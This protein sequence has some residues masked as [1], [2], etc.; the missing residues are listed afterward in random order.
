MKHFKNILCVIER[1][2]DEHYAL[3]RAVALAEH[4]QARVMV[5]TVTEPVR[6]V[7]R[8]SP[9]GI[10]RARLQDSLTAA[11][12]EYLATLI[13]PYKARVNIT[14]KVLSGPPFLEVVREVLREAHDLVIKCPKSPDWLDRFLSSDDMHLLRKC[15]CPVWLVK[16]QARES[17]H[18]ILAGVDVDDGYAPE[19]LETRRALNGMVVELAG[20]LAV[21]ELAQL[22]VANAWEAPGE[23]VMRY[24]AFMQRPG[25]EVDDYVEQV[26][27]HHSQLLDALM[28]QASA[29]LGK[30]AIDHIKPQLHMPKGTARK[31]IP[32]LAKQ[33]RVDCIVMGTVARTG[34]SGF[35]MGNTAETILGQIDCS[36]LAIKPP[37]FVTPVALDD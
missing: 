28:T 3:E 24:G 31:E 12:A 16:P 22:H 29:A 9:E 7:S 2:S 36:V 32:S 18:R 19:E 37:G 15:P 5:V 20:S 10:G 1:R 33:L 6:G 27:G 17:Y 4:N 13:E 14:T 23:G 30:D 11:Q 35:I 21:S 26:R 8:P 34:I 25:A